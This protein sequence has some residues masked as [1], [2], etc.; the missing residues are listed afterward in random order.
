MRCSSTTSPSSS[1]CSRS[2]SWPGGIRVSSNLVGTPATNTAMLTLGTL[3]ASIVGTTGASM[4]LIRPMIEA[5]QDRRRNVHVF[6]FFIFLVANIGGALTP[7]GDPPLFLGFIKGVDFFWVTEAMFA[8][9]MLLSVSLL[10]LFYLIDRLAW[11]HEADKIKQQSRAPRHIRIE[12][13]H[14]VLYLGL[15]RRGG[16]GERLMGSSHRCA[17]RIWLERAARRIGARHRR[18]L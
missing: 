5:N 15:G 10:L 7:L 3:S 13:L 11:R 17:S 14:N 9:M 12:G 1:S 6:V 18:Y 2:S 4:L 8:P 16:A